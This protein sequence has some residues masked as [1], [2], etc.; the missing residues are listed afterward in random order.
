ILFSIESPSFF[1]SVAAGIAVTEAL[2][3]I[4]VAEGGADIPDTI[5]RAE[6]ELFESG[7]YV[8]PPTKRP[9]RR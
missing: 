4:L 3:E 7:A 2:L 6:K 1:P 9:S 5:D 8:L